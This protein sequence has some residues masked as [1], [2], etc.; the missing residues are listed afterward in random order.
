MLLLLLFN[1]HDVDVNVKNV[2]VVI[3]VGSFSQLYNR[4]SNVPDL[5][6]SVSNIVSFP[7]TCI[8]PNGSSRNVASETEREE[9]IKT[10]LTHGDVKEED[11]EKEEQVKEKEEQGVHVW[12][13]RVWVE[14]LYQCPQW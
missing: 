4:W 3:K 9:N 13:K 2:L 8:W 7:F 1:D 12:V 11:E 5:F 6:R 10:L 14:P